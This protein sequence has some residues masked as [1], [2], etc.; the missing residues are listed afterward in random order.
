MTEVQRVLVIDDEKINLKVISDI[1]RDEVEIILA[2]SGPQGIRKAIEYMPDL[3]LLDVLMPDMD[4]FE[5]MSVLRHDVRTCA[6]PVIFVTALNDASHEEKGLLLGASDYIQKP[7]HTAIVQA[8]IRLHLQLAKQRSMLERLAN[9]DPLTSLANRRKYQEE[10]TLQWEAAV[11]KKGSI[12]LAVIDIDDFKKY[13]DCHGHA[14]GDKVLQQVA[15]T[16]SEQFK[17]P[18]DLV[19]RYGGEEFVVLLPDKT[20]DEALVV[21]QACR[22]AIEKLNI[23]Y[24]DQH[25]NGTVTI[26]TGGVTFFP[27][28]DRDIES[29]FHKA[30]EMLYLAKRNGKNRVLWFA[31]G[32]KAAENAVE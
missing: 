27:E 18:Q 29:F 22:E 28:R 23:P 14:A 16:L 7:L 32:H 1:L 21:L 17:Q 9:I 26:S 12:S 30:D 24:D 6:I 4:G 5:T 20:K 13:N 3:I 19:A 15:D 2:K 10:L 31:S 8:R 25:H 11:E